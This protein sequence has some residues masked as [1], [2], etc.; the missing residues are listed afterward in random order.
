MPAKPDHPARKTDAATPSARAPGM[1][2]SRPELGAKPTR[3]GFY[4]N[5]TG[6]ATKDVNLRHGG[7]QHSGQPQSGS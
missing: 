1:G 7:A 5:A 4:G 3:L 2:D 6:E